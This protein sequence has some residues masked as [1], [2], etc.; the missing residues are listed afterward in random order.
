MF[1]AWLDLPG[2]QSDCQLR[3]VAG[4][5]GESEVLAVL[6]TWDPHWEHHSTERC[7]NH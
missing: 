6:R 3:S 1:Q 7:L 5:L 2:V 4:T